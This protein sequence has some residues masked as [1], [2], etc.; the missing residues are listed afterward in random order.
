MDL[1]PH[2]PESSTS[3]LPEEYVQAQAEHRANFL[4]VLMFSVVMFCVVSAF[5]IT[6]RR[7]EAVRTE[8]AR[9][10]QE[11]AAE[12]AKLSQLEEIRSRRVELVQKGELVHALIEPVPR[13][14][15]LADLSARL[16]RGVS[17]SLVELEGKRIS[18]LI[19]AQAAGQVR[20]LSQTANVAQQNATDKGSR[21]LIIP[22][23]FD[24]SLTI[25]GVSPTNQ[26]IADYMSGLQQSELLTGVELEL[27]QQT[28]VDDFALRKFEIVAMLRPGAHAALLDID[29][30]AAVEGTPD[31][32]LDLY[33]VPPEIEPELESGG[34]SQMAG[35]EID[36]AEQLA[37]ASGTEG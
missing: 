33:E 27:I 14:V 31:D 5:L 4:T 18:G 26:A 21:P 30:L 17:L 15:L 3:M 25:E 24:F 12:A 8:Q 9:I 36:D 35:V 29:S 20:T 16:P 13:S 6:T 19:G 7:W 37:E 11:Y 1:A 22:P 10:N 2:R 32:G 34:D 23:R 28:M